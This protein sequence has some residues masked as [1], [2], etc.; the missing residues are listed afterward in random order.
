MNKSPIIERH[1]GAARPA[2]IKP[3]RVALPAGDEAPDL[4]GDAYQALL[5]M[6][7]RGVLPPETPLQERTLAATLG[8]S[9]TPLR[10]AMSRL[11]GGGFAVRTSRGQLVVKEPVLRQYLEIFQIRVLLE[12]EAA[13]CAATRLDE[14]SARAVMA[15]VQA[16]LTAGSSSIEENHRVDNLVHDTIAAASGNPMLAQLI[17]DLRIKARCFD[18]NG[19]PERFEPGC[20]EH[21]AI[22]QAIVERNPEAAREAMRRHLDTVRVGLVARHTRL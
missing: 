4:A 18:Q 2:P 22:L 16:L 5:D 15:E 3:A 10:E 9:R 1:G 19:A 21:I 6:I 13:A 14:Q 12:A 7:Q 11:I 17:H 20:R 8:I